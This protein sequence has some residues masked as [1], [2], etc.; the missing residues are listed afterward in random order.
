MQTQTV[1]QQRSP[2][3]SG[4]NGNF[5]GGI[6]TI[7]ANGQMAKFLDES[8]FNGG[9]S[10]SG[11]VIFTSS[12][13]VV[14]VAL[15]GL[16]NERGEFLVTTLPVA[17]LSVP[18]ASSTIIFPQF[19]D[20]GGWTT[21]IV[22][23]NPGDSLITGTVQFLNPSGGTA[24]VVVNGQANSSFAYSIPARSSQKLQTAGAAP[25]TQAGSVRVIPDSRAA[26]PSG[27]AIFS[28]RNAGI[29]VTEAGVPAVGVGT[30]FRLYAKAAGNLSLPGSIQTGLAVTN[31]YTS[32]ASVLLELHKL[33]GSP[34][35]LT[36]TLSVS[37]NGRVA[38]FLNE[39]QGL[40]SLQKPFQGIL[41]VSSPSSISLPPRLCS[42]H[43][44]ST[45][46]VT[47]HNSFCL[48]AEPV[49]PHPV[50][51]NSSPQ[52]V[53]T[54]QTPTCSGA[55]IAALSGTTRRS[56][57]SIVSRPLYPA[58][59]RSRCCSSSQCGQKWM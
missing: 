16:T 13:P 20:G 22:L 56:R 9:S 34:T 5:G 55:G 31:T 2:L 27:L 40:A 14:V 10:F 49:S 8:P 7:P 53:R 37:P 32:A 58:I 15:R 57:P 54:L 33:E 26:A 21:Q 36:G 29:T 46:E 17:D 19:A 38:T 35:G 51:S 4:P 23:V 48:A 59:A 47:L 11:T 42:S 18:A 1:S 30:A 45:R 43:T 6:I 28:F 3:F 41:R 25:S 50:R 44:S 24:G 52:Y 39:T 12:V